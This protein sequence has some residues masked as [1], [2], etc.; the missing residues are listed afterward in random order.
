M[1][2]SNCAIIRGLMWLHQEKMFSKW[3]EKF[4][5]VT[6]DYIQIYKKGSVEGTQM[7]DF[8]FQVASSNLNFLTHSFKDKDK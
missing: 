1:F 8:Q 6:K 7:G 3:K 5:V 4:L 2:S